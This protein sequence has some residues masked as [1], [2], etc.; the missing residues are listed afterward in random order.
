MQS[1]NQNHHAK[2]QPTMGETLTVKIKEHSWDE[3][4][5]L[6]WNKTETIHKEGTRIMRKN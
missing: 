1:I 6:W 3:D 4:H 5:R 2:I